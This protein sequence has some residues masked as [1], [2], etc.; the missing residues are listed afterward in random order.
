MFVNIDF[1]CIQQ[2]C[3]HNLHVCIA[4]TILFI[5]LQ[6]NFE[7]GLYSSMDQVLPT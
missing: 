1:I 4:L 6:L 2:S 5:F 7:I 3:V